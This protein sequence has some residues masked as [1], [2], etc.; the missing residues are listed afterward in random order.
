MVFCMSKVK[1]K[2]HPRPAHEGPEGDYR[3]SFTLSVTSAL[4]GDGWS[5]PRPGRFTRGKDPVP[6]VKETG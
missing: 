6:F 5:T 3:Y 4:D 1:S 2:G